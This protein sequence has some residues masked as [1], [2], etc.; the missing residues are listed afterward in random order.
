MLLDIQSS[1]IERGYGEVAY[2]SRLSGDP[3]F[4]LTRAVVNAQHIIRSFATSYSFYEVRFLAAGVSASNVSA[5]TSKENTP[6]K[7]ANKWETHC[8]Y[9]L[10][11]H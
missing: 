8:S 7:N 9:F 2:R 5:L 1:R 10:P 3:Y 11:I 6:E 4:S